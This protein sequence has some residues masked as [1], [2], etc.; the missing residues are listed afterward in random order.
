MAKEKLTADQ[1]A[2]ILGRI[3]KS[4]IRRGL[5]DADIVVEAA[6]AREDLKLGLFKK[7]DEICK[8]GVILATNTSSF[9]SPGTPAPRTPR[10]GHR[11]ASS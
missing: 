9:R 7:L 6:V 11:H 4:T 8:P 10:T 5:K 2:E 1:K 3:K